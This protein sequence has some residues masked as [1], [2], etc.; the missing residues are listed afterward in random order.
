[1]NGTGHGHRWTTEELKKLMLLWSDGKPLEEIAIEL[2]VSRFGAYKMVLKLREQGIPMPK[3]ERGAAK[4]K[5]YRAWSQAELEYLIRRRKDGTTAE[6]IAIEL[7]RTFLAIQGMISKLRREGVA[8]QQ[9]GQ[10]RHA[11]YDMNAVRAKGQ[12]IKES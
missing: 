3:R 1:M 7:N 8:V 12:E 11:L 10:G 9:Y 6:E 5:S 4:H 2:G